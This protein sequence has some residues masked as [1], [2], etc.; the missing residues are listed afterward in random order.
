[1]VRR[2]GGWAAKSRVMNESSSSSL[3]SSSLDSS[4]EGDGTS[5]SLNRSLWNRPV[6]LRS[7]GVQSNRG[8]SCRIVLPNFSSRSQPFRDRAKDAK[9]AKEWPAPL[10]LGGLGDLGASLCRNEAVEIATDGHG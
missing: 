6:A 10:P 3:N 9:G 5:S 4:A 7:V 8:E 1:M 2:F